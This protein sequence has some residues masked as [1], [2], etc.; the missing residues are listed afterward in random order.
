MSD[1]MTR[2]AGRTLGVAPVVQPPTVPMFAPEPTSHPVDLAWDVEE[3]ASSSDLD[4]AESSPVVKKPPARDAPAGRPERPAMDLQDDQS[5]VA[6]ATPGHT[7]GTSDPR[8]EP[9]RPAEPGPTR[10]DA[11]MTSSRRALPENVLSDPPLAEDVSSRATSR[12]IETHVERGRGTSLTPQSLPDTQGGALTSEVRA[13]SPSAQDA[14]AGQPE[15]MDTTQQG[16]YRNL[17]PAETPGR[18]QRTP[19]TRSELHHPAEPDPT[20]GDETVF[21]SPCVL[22]EDSLSVTEGDLDQA[23]PRL[24]RTPA[25]QN[26]D[27]GVVPGP[28]QA[29]PGTQESMPESTSTQDRSVPP[30]AL[31][32]APRVI[33]PRLDGD[34]ERG[35]REP[36]VVAPEPHEPTVRVAIGR[37]EVRAITPPPAQ[38]AMPVRSGPVLS[39]DDYLKQHN[40]RRR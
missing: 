39:L 10:R 18:P 5:H 29:S 27:G 30:D 16:D 26:Q 35:P 4:R 17:P 1:F 6:P 20:R 40:G 38:Q 15:D 2:L 8:F 33:R 21:T 31:P 12:S 7:R 34:L 9:H 23:I 32:V 14:L 22:P 25:E 37:I 11:D 13:P 36:R 3:P 19:I 28:S 24:I